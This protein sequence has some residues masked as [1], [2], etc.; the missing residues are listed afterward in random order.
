M[1]RS[2]WDPL[3]LLR[4]QPLLNPAAANCIWLSS[5]RDGDAAVAV[6]DTAGDV[7]AAAVGGQEHEGGG[8]LGGLAR[9]AHRHLHGRL[10]M[11]VGAGCQAGGQM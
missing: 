2:E 6:Q 1:H 4:G 3:L 8:H 7:G 5:R 11:R 9:T 10:G